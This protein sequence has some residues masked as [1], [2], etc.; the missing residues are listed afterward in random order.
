M[1]VDRSALC[2]LLVQLTLDF[3]PVCPAAVGPWAPSMA[4]HL[5]WFCPSTTVSLSLKAADQDGK[6]AMC[7]TF[8][9]V[10]G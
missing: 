6:P 1:H 8:D 5:K 7:L 10:I 9:I 3:F 4:V 2:L